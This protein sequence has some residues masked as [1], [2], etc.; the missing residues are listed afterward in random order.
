WRRFLVLL[1]A[2]T[3]VLAEACCCALLMVGLGVASSYFIQ[4]LVDSVLIRHEGRLLNALGIGMGLIT[5]FRTVFGML[6]QYLV[7]SVSRKVTLT[8]TAGYARHLL[9]LP[10]PFFEMQRVGEILSRVND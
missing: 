3:P 6:R 9:G 8:L 4:H 5:L 2:H 7:A 1:G 10:L